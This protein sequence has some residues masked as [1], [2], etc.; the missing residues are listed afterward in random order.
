MKNKNQQIFDLISSMPKKK[1]NTLFEMVLVRTQIKKYEYELNGF[2]SEENKKILS[3]F[4]KYKAESLNYEF[5]EGFIKDK[6]INLNAVEG[7]LLNMYALAGENLGLKKL[8]K[9]D[10]VDLNLNKGNTISNMIVRSVKYR[11]LNRYLN[12]ITIEKEL[13]KEL[14]D[15]ALLAIHFSKHYYPIGL[16]L[17]KLKKIYKN[18]EKLL[19]KLIKERTKRKRERMKFGIE[20]LNEVLSIIKKKRNINNF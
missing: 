15:Q 4:L 7:H 1:K 3:H 10:R 11:M 2:V 6:D 9:E 19:I 14:L 13:E 5:I 8:L 18:E 12:K 17:V 16:I 20:H